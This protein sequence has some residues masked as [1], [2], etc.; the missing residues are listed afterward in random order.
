MQACEPIGTPTP[1]TSFTTTHGGTDGSCGLDG[2]YY[3]P[4]SE[5]NDR[6]HNAE[7]GNAMLAYYVGNPGPGT[8]SN[9]DAFYG[10][11]FGYCPY[12]QATF[13]CDANY[14]NASNELSD[15]SLGAFK[16]AGYFFGMGGLFTNSWPAV[17]AGGVPPAIPRTLDVT[18]NISSVTNATQCRVTLTKPDGS[19]VSNT[20]N[21]SPCPVTADAR[22]GDHLLKV[23]YLNA[24]G[25]VLASAEP[26]PVRVN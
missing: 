24:S 7:A 4:S 5:A 2:L 12:T 18:C 17:R 15:N 16:W 10:Q 21:T 19:T 25:A 23:E 26:Q 9:T 11:V 22:E 20:C 1:G 3:L 8:Q 14:V 13:Y 6:S